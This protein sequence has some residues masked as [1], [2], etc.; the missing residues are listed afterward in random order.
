MKYVKSMTW[1]AGL[2]VA[3]L[4]LAANIQIDHRDE[5]PILVD[6]KPYQ[7]GQPTSNVAVITTADR[8]EHT[9]PENAC[10][11][12]VIGSSVTFSENCPVP[13]PE[14]HGH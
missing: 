2:L 3:Q 7:S 6:G 5:S 4:G 1:I 8:V 11:A 13:Q 12:V 9:V 14:F 10:S